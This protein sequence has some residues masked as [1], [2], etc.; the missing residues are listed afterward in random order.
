V[1]IK[2]TH[3]K[4]FFADVHTVLRP[5][6]SPHLEKVTFNFLEKIRQ[7]SFEG[8]EAA[9]TWENT[10]EVLYNLSMRWPPRKLLLVIK[11]K[12]DST[13]PIG[14]L[15]GMMKGL[16]PRFM[17]VGIVETEVS[18]DIAQWPEHVI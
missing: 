5:V 10:D 12:F 7:A 1:E 14:D 16:L 2:L 17:D 9:N 18:A 3:P 11:G 4:C 8:P 6:P 15:A 13:P